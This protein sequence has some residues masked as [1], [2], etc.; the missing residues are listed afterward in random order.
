MSKTT[1]KSALLLIGALTLSLQLNIAYSQTPSST[2]TTE[3]IIQSLE[4]SGAL[5][6]AIDRGI[7]RYRQK[8]INAAQAKQ[9]KEEAQK[10]AMA[11][12]ARAVDVKNDF[13]YGKPDAVISIIEYSDFECPFCK[14][15]G[16]IPNKVVDSMPDQVNLVWRNFPLSFHD[17]VATKEAIAAA[18]AAQQGGNN[19]F[20]KYAQGIFKNTRSNAQ[21]MPSVNGVDP[22]LALA[23]E[24]GLDTDKFSTCMQSEAVA[25]Q[26][27]ADLEDGMNAG[28]SGTPGVI[29][30]N[31]KTGAF[32]VLAGAVPEDVLKQE[33]KN[34]LNAKK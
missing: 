12:N 31:H 3:Q 30:V 34:L 9:Q 20:W 23:K 6:R 26:V 5:D 18:C 14:Q 24:Q 19:A 25:K 32:N 33:V 28:I 4:K 27:S 21:G 13:I 15:F 2:P 22:L 7:E 1:F 29:L 17:P 16:D 11:K 8:Q 10:V